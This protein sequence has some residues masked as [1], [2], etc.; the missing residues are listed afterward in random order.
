MDVVGAAAW[1]VGGERAA[2]EHAAAVRSGAVAAA[3]MAGASMAQV[4]GLRGVDAPA[5]PE[6]AGWAEGRRVARSAAAAAEAEAIPAEESWAAQLEAAVTGGV[7]R[8][9]VL[10]AAAA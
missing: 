4:E 9:V 2:V 3:P 6:V 8:A 1:Q 5:A 7:L 10:T